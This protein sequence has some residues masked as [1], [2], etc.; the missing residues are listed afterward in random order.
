MPYWTT[1]TGGFTVERRLARTRADG[2]ALDEWRELNARWFQY[3]TFCPLL[4]V[5]GQSSARDVEPRRRVHARLSVRAEVRSPPLRAAAVHLFA[6]RRRSPRTVDDDAPAGDGLPR[7]RRRARD[8]RTSTCS[9]RR[10][11]SARSRLQ[12]AEPSVYLPAGQDWYDFW[13]GDAAEGGTTMTGG[14]A[15]FRPLPLFVR[16]GSIVPVRVQMHQYIG[17]SPAR[18]TPLYVYAGANGA[19]SLYEDDGATYGYEKAQFSTIPIAGTTRPDAH[20]RRAV[21]IVSR[22]ARRAAPSTSCSCPRPARWD[23]RPRRNARVRCRPRAARCASAF[24]S[25]SSKRI[26]SRSRRRAAARRARS[27]RESVRRM[28]AATRV[29]RAIGRR[30]GPFRRLAPGRD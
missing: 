12:G 3:S 11:S 7:R 15:V 26:G 19:F 25:D 13:T 29:S 17:E 6:G 18:R 30:A 23:I 2:D 4:R 16:A 20:D 1:D 10:S 24:R 27:A 21:R 22:H 9:G 14:R 5:H 28:S 8:R